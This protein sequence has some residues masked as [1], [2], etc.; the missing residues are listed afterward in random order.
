MLKVILENTVC[1]NASDGVI[2]LAAEKIIKEAFGD[3]TEL[4][5]FDHDA[6]TSQDI[7]PEQYFR[8]TIAGRLYTVNPKPGSWS[9]W[10][11]SYKNFK[12][13]IALWAAKKKMWG[14]VTFLLGYESGG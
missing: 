14:L 10:K 12:S 1:G 7:Y 3:D 4:M 6:E 2:M 5:V 11:A 8:P 13:N 9:R